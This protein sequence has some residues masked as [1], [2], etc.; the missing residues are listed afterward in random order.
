MLYSVIVFAIKKANIFAYVPQIYLLF[1]VCLLFS[2]M[3]MTD[4]FALTDRIS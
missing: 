3:A 2:D 1:L 4:A